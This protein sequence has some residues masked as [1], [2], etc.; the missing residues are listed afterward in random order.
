MYKDSYKKKQ[1]RIAGLGKQTIFSNIY[2]APFNSNKLT[3]YFALIR[4]GEKSF[5]TEYECRFRSEAVS[6]FNE[7]ARLDNGYVE[8]IGVFK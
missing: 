4:V 3:K 2:E 6:I 8:Y 1:H 7:K 5:L